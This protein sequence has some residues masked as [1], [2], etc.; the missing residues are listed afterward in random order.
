MVFPLISLGRVAQ[1]Q[2][3]HRE[4]QHHFQEGLA[5]RI[6]FHDQR[7]VALC[8]RSLGDTAMALG[9]H[10]EARWFYQE[11]LAIFRDLG[12]EEGA[13][14]ALTGLGDVALAHGEMAQARAA[15]VAALANA[16]RAGSAPRILD[17]AAGIAAVLAPAD[18][19]G[20]AGLAA[21]VYSHPAATQ[22][23]RN[24]ASLVLARDSHAPARG[25]HAAPDLSLEQIIREAER[26]AALV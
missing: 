18:E 13:V 5:I 11:A 1:A 3:A 21:L 12:N 26:L 16:R 23:C 9:D 6:A 8:L 10:G 24:R 19:P 25:G 4:A 20:A 2:G 22:A 17:A 15:F 14:T 7:G